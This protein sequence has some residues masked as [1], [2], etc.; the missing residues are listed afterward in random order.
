MIHRER[1]KQTDRHTDE[2]I[3]LQLGAWSIMIL[4]YLIILTYS[5]TKTNTLRTSVV[6]Q[7]KTNSLNPRLPSRSKT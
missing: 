5:T 1:D 2:T 3:K 7:T 4:I 6:Q